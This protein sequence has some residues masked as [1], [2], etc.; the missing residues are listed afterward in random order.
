MQPT[1]TALRVGGN[2]KY[3]LDSSAKIPVPRPT[4]VLVRNVAVALNPA[5]A[6]MVDL[7]ASSGAIGGY[8][9]AG[10]IV[11][12]GSEVTR[13]LKIGDRV[14]GPVFGN[15]PGN[16]DCGAFCEYVEVEAQLVL[17]IPDN[18]S[19]EDGAGLGIASATVGMALYHS[20]GLPMAPV[21]RGKAQEE[22]ALVYGGSTSCGTLAV[23]LLVH[24]GYKVIATCSPK[25]FP[26]LKS[27]RA[28]GVFDYRSP[29]CASD[30]LK[31]TKNT[32]GIVLDCITDRTTMKLCYGV[33]GDKG[34]KYT[35]LDPFPI[36]MHT[37]SDITPHW[38]FVLTMF[39]QA[40]AMKGA[41]KRKKRPQDVEFAKKWFVRMQELLDGNVIK[42]HPIRVIPGGLDAVVEGINELRLGKVSGEKLVVRVAE[43]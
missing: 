7:S 31:A 24:S 23:Q 27:L 38:V 8:D 2:G 29:N 22:F 35:S 10:E 17:R 18:M 42:P 11:T 3:K 41:F 26:L 32:L 9:F 1:Q 36:P 5:D 15:N 6:K 20:I 33:M 14:C 13:D 28:T 37:R 21:S 40:I 16:P 34:G 19:F 39:G 30:I 43:T 4:C 25:N 12:V